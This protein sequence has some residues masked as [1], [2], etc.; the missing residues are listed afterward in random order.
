M[1][2]RVNVVTVKKEFNVNEPVDTPNVINYHN[3]EGKHLY[4][5]PEKASWIALTDTGKEF[6]EYFHQGKTIK[7]SFELLMNRGF[8]KNNLTDE[9]RNLLIKMDKNGFWEAAALRDKASEI[10]LHLYLT[11]RCNQLCTH[12]YM[13]SGVS[14]ASGE[15]TT[16]EIL[17]LIEK[18]SER[19]K[20]KVTLTGGEPL[21]RS[22]FFEI[23]AFA[24]K[25]GLQVEVFTNGSLINEINKKQLETYVNTIQMS[26]DGPTP[27]Y[28]DPIRGQGTY[29]NVKRAVHLLKNGPIKLRVASVLIPANYQAFLN[30]YQTFAAD[31]EK[32]EFKFSLI[33]KE[34]R[35]G[36]S[37]KFEPEYAGELAI[38]ELL[39]KFYSA[40]LKTAGIIE[41]NWIV[42]NCGYGEV[43]AISSDGNVYPC[44]LLYKPH[45]NIRRNDINEIMDKIQQEAASCNV[46]NIELCRSCDLIHLCFGGCRLNNLIH[47]NN[48]LAPHCS[49]ERKK[50]IYKKL[51][52]RDNFDGLAYWL[53]QKSI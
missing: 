50:N 37:L 25:M 18:F 52:I 19:S 2:K 43:I 1:P 28:N 22:D 38:Q 36:S 41:P 8:E 6:L 14:D 21:L 7:E 40:K 33:I 12:C 15:M 26:V 49:A 20:T 51:V 24:Q 47:N 39:K 5:A 4:I 9:L 35:A 23:A 11:N 13:N 3:I 46:E 44:A 31:F 45:G 48:L 32:A 29:E 53:G 16:E 27:E 42:H 17:K 34:G 10:Y 30:H